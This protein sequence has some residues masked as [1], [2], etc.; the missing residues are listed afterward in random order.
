MGF[1]RKFKLTLD[2]VMYGLLLF[3]LSYKPGSGLLLH[4]KIGL[5]LGGL[6]ILHLTRLSE[7]KI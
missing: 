6:F 7:L 4:G 1:E 2:V 3:L 5:A